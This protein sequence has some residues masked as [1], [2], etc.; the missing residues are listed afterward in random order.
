[1]F[2]HWTWRHNGINLPHH[3]HCAILCLTRTIERE[4]VGC[5]ELYNNDRL[6][7]TEQW[8]TSKRKIRRNIKFGKVY[9]TLRFCEFYVLNVFIFQYWTVLDSSGTL[10]RKV[11][12]LFPKHKVFKVRTEQCQNDCID[13]SL[14]WTHKP[15]PAR[16]KPHV[17]YTVLS[18]THPWN[19]P[20]NLCMCVPFRI[21]SQ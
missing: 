17:T 8:T 15:N 6:S 4:P 19:K 13:Q 18:Q 2:Y 3:D 1:M 11:Q 20:V 16:S 10:R 9:G 14:T 21:G 7:S 5:C 12:E